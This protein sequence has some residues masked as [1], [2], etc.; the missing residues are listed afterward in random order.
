MS[1]VLP[2][3]GRDLGASYRWFSRGQGAVHPACWVG[4]AGNSQAPPLPCMVMWSVQALGC[5]LVLP[6]VKSLFSELRCGRG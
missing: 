1:L 6:I 2:V 3:G 4:G 5:T